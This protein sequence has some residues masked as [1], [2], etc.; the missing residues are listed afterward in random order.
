MK[1]IAALSFFALMMAGVGTTYAFS[2]S[3]EAIPTWFKQSLD[4]RINEIKDETS[5]KTG[6]AIISLSTDTQLEKQ[7]A[8][9]QI[10]NF[11][12]NEVGN[13]KKA[14]NEHKDH[15]IQ[16]LH[17]A[18]EQLTIQHKQKMKQYKEQL[19]ERE[20]AQ[21]K[22]DTIAILSDLLEVIEE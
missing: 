22:M 15:S 1:R 4:Q 19:K 5:G 11:K 2:N 14:I 17:E 12:L 20:A 3:G 7:N 18:K 6:I 13:G 9:N 21:I 16:Q 10:L 8:E